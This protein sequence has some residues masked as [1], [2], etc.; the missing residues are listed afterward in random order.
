MNLQV[1][2][3]IDKTGELISQLI[4]DRNKCRTKEGHDSISKIIQEKWD[5]IYE[6]EECL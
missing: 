5:F 4:E 2:K 1:K 6:L 3:L